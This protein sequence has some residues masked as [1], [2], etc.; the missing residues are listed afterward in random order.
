MKQLV[1]EIVHRFKLHRGDAY[2][3]HGCAATRT[4]FIWSALPI[5]MYAPGHLQGAGGEQPERDAAPGVECHDLVRNLVRTAALA[6]CGTG[7]YGA[8]RQACT[9][10]HGE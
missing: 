8:P 9:R 5:L 3:C 7:E 1:E 4:V 2:R 6:L 10:P